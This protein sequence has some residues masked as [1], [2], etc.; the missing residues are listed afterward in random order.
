M[1]AFINSFEA[2][3]ISSRKTCSKKTTTTK[4]NNNSICTAAIKK[5]YLN[6]FEQ[7]PVGLPSAR[8]QMQMVFNYEEMNARS[9]KC[10]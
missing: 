5:V 2:L 8:V 4:K 10:I 9:N 3:K 7:Y 1:K 6:S